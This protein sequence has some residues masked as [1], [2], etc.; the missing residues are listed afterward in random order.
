MTRAQQLAVLGRTLQRRL[1]EIEEA[2]GQSADA[3][4]A[5]KLDQT[6]VG[7]LSR[8]DAMQQQATRVTLRDASRRE[9][10][11]V[12]AALNR[13]AAGSYGVCCRCEDEMPIE[14]LHADPAAPFCMECEI[15]VKGIAKPR[16]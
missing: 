3:L 9:L 7:R 10:R 11:R 14:R 15:A 16:R 2:L 1:A 5:L 13:V 4:H 6:G 12:Q 8:M